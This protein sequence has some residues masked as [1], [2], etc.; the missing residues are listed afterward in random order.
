MWNLIT[1]NNHFKKFVLTFTFLISF[2]FAYAQGVVG[3]IGNAIGNG[4]AD[5]IARYFDNA[6]SLT[7]SGNQSTYSR[8]QAE[9]I[10]KDFFNKNVVKGFS[11]EHSGSD[12]NNSYMIGTLATSHGKYRTYFSVRQKDG[13][14]V[15]QEIRFEK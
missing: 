15:I 1:M 14:Y 2:V 10:L 11:A 4:N 13:S 3:S 5:G 9:M 12:N 8:S 7:I 6:V